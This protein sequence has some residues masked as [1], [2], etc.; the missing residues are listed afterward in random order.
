MR[1][2]FRSSSLVPSGLVVDYVDIGADRTDLVM[3]SGAA[4][5]NCPDC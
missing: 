1:P 4:V 3:R 5:T 2:R